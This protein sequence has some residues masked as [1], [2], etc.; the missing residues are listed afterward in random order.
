MPFKNSEALAREAAAIL[1]NSNLRAGME[2]ST[3]DYG[4]RMSWEAVAHRYADIFRSVSSTTAQ[5]ARIG[6]LS[7]ARANRRR[8]LGV[9]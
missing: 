6:M 9:T 8:L 3:R 4:R 5:P 1:S 7:A 2:M